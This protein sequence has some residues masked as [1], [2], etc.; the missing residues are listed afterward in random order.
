MIRSVEDGQVVKG[1]CD[2]AIFKRNRFLWIHS[3]DSDGGFQFTV[4]SF[5]ILNLKCV[6]G[7][8]SFLSDLSKRRLVILPDSHTN[9]TKFV[10][11]KSHCCVEVKSHCCVEVKS[12][13][14]FDVCVCFS[15]HLDG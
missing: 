15:L 6:Y 11:V 7:H 9:R 13:A 5:P 14:I 2:V 4:K 3:L 1:S 12:S 10:G 8:V